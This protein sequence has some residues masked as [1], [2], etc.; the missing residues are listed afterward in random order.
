MSQSMFGNYLELFASTEIFIFVFMEI[1][2]KIDIIKPVIFKKAALKNYL[3]FTAIFGLFSV[4]GTYIGTMQSTGAITNIR[5][6]A[7][8][9]AGLL[10]GPFV[11]LSV[12]LIGGIHR[13]FLGG[14]TQIPCSLATVLAGLLGGIVFRLNKGKLLGIVPGMLFGLGIELMHGGLALLIVQPFSVALDVVKANIPQM[15]VAISLGVGISLVIIHSAKE[16]GYFPTGKNR[17]PEGSSQEL[18]LSEAN[19]GLSCK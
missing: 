16:P 7:P 3:V 14:V 5:D 1:V 18:A 11:G 9:V 10:G 19:C 6:L 15:A 8:I 4:F 13:F 2:T 12:G 17:A